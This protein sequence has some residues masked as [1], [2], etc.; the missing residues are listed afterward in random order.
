MEEDQ[1]M[2]SDES[3]NMSGSDSE[4][5][6]VS[7]I[8]KERGLEVRDRKKA[9]TSLR[10]GNKRKPEMRMGSM[11]GRMTSKNESKKSFGSRLQSEDSRRKS[12]GHKMSRTA[13]GGM[14]MSFTPQSVK[15]RNA[16][17]TNNRRRA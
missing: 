3:E 2:D 16:K 5:D 7:K 17:N 13:M 10:T 12:E 9:S 15:K 6:L 4:D 8:R 14:E 1:P 11:G